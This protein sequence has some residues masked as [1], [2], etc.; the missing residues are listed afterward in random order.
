MSKKSLSKVDT[1]RR[2]NEL[3]AEEIEAGLR[4]LHLSVTVTGLE[5]LLIQKTL[6]ENMQETLEHAQTIGERILHLGGVPELDLR[7]QI[8]AEKTTAGNAIRTAKEF[9]QAA[10]DAY[11]ELLEDVAADPDGDVTLEEF[12]REQVAVESQHVAELDLLLEG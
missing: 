9:E 5:R 6:L 2:L 1:I 4:Y 11:R 3:F 7:V 10:L 8:P 12:L